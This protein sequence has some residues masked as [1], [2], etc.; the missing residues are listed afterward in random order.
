MPIPFELVPSNNPING[1]L[2]VT[3]PL[4]SHL[5]SNFLYV[6][7]LIAISHSDSQ[8]ALEIT[9]I[10]SMPLPSHLKSQKILLKFL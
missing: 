3:G 10:P 1:K 4:L 8:F 6:S 7:N 9:T 5:P 2:I